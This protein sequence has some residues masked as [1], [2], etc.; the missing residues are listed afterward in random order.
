MRDRNELT[1]SWGE[2]EAH[3]IM[4]GLMED[5]GYIR[6][7]SELNKWIETYNE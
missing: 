5:G 4:L 3:Q 2:I 7:D 1:I 6:F